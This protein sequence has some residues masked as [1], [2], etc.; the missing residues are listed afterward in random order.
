MV[1]ACPPVVKFRT[2]PRTCPPVVELVKKGNPAT[3]LS[4]PSS[5]DSPGA[6]TPSPGV[7]TIE[8]LLPRG[9][10]GGNMTAQ[11]SAVRFGHLAVRRHDAGRRAARH[12]LV[13][14]EFGDHRCVF[15]LGH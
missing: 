3:Q 1:S 5:V 15:D 7:M 4:A 14:D 6:L 10:P 2:V 8:L 9:L 13:A 11:R 12:T